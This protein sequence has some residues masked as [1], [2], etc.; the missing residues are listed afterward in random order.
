MYLGNSPWS[1]RRTGETPA[2]PTVFSEQSLMSLWLS[3]NYEKY[4]LVCYLS[5]TNDG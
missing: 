4:F 1:L 5:F 3:Q 2:P